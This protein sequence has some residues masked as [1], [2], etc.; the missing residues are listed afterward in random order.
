[1]YVLCCVRERKPRCEGTAISAAGLGGSGELSRRHGI[2]RNGHCSS[3]LFLS[4]FCSS[5]NSQGRMRARLGAGERN[6]SD[7]STHAPAPHPKY[8]TT[9]TQTSSFPL[10]SCSLGH[11]RLVVA[12][13]SDHACSGRRSSA[14]PAFVSAVR[15]G[16]ETSE[17]T[18]DSGSS[19]PPII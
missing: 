3:I 4:R 8:P 19:S 16:L 10:C 9:S 2:R 12:R 13:P 5:S 17:C 15:E 6:C 1:M 7:D 11:R 18:A 14:P